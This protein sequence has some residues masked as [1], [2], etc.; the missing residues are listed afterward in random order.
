MILYIY[1]IT[2]IISKVLKKRVYIYIYIYKIKKKRIYLLAEVTKEKLV[3]QLS[4]MNPTPS[5]TQFC[6]EPQN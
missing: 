3:R 5:I 4:Q 1:I 6:E 2:Y